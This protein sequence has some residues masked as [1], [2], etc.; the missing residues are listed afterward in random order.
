[1]AKLNI[2]DYYKNVASDNPYALS[3]DAQSI[4]SMYDRATAA[5]QAVEERGIA[6]A[7]AAWQRNLAGTQATAL[8]TIRKNNA[9]AIATGASK[10]M[11]AAN[12]LSAVLGL[13]DTA[14]EESTALA[15]QRLDLADAYAA[16]YAKNAVTAQETAD[17]NK[18]AM[19]NA[20]IQQ[21]GY[22]TTAGAARYNSES[23]GLIAEALAAYE[24]G[25]VNLGNTI[26]KALGTDYMK[27]NI[28]ETAEDPTPVLDAGTYDSAG[29]FGWGDNK[30]LAE[31]M[32][33]YGSD[34]KTK[35]GKIGGRVTDAGVIAALN[36]AGIQPGQIL[37]Y[38]GINY[39]K[40]AGGVIR[41]LV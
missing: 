32:A 31:G 15:Q 14:V 36:K 29:W 39:V 16:E 7:E 37:Q 19:M 11:Q 40:G 30:V 33:L 3:T 23:T 4:K 21:Y 25:D 18:Q 13:Q 1:M 20:A 26:M 28:P 9:S 12:E 17:A 8:D 24:S 35:L 2:Q 22:D 5:A 38:R 10:G 34:G 27:T 41:Q 6:N